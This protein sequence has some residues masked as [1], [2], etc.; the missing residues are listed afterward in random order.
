M[1]T[2]IVAARPQS[3]HRG[4]RRADFRRIAREGR[5]TNGPLISASVAPALEGRGRVGFTAGRRVGN[6]VSRNRARRLLRE[7]WRSVGPEGDLPV[8]IVLVAQPDMAGRVLD[9]VRAEMA[10]ILELAG[11]I[12]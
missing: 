8:D 4:L 1:S 10:R 9:D 6:A 12:R 3:A 11:V 7:A 2:S 5:R